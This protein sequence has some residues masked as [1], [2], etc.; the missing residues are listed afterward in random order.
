MK[1]FIK[2]LEIPIVFIVTIVALV[3]GG[4]MVITISPI[5]AILA[6]IELFKGDT[7]SS[8]DLVNDFDDDEEIGGEC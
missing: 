7:L 6:V 8:G 3:L 5:F 4:V 2:I 1:T